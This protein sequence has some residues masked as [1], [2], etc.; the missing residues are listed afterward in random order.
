MSETIAYIDD[1]LAIQKPF[2]GLA[3]N[4]DSGRQVIFVVGVFHLFLQ[5]TNVYCLEY[6]AIQNM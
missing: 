4:T 5:C 3:H 2:S 6:A 1:S